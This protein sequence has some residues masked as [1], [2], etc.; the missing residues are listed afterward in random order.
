MTTITN[1]ISVFSSVTSHRRS[2]FG[3]RMNFSFVW[4]LSRLRSRSGLAATAER[5]N[6]RPLC[7]QRVRFFRR[8]VGNAGLFGLRG[9]PLEV[10]SSRRKFTNCGYVILTQYRKN[11]KAKQGKSQKANLHIVECN[12]RNM[13]SPESLIKSVSSSPGQG[14]GNEP[15]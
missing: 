14:E 11:T 13:L 3:W 12:K 5:R 1:G 4:A 8:L 7:S 2:V 9:G 10:R 15:S 6:C